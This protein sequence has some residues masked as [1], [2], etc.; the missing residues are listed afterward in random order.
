MNYEGKRNKLESLKMMFLY[1]WLNIN[2]DIYK[3]E[4]IDINYSLCFFRSNFYLMRKV[5]W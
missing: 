4:I 1:I 2:C 3:N 5:F